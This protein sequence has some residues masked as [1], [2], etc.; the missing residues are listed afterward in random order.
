MKL[1]IIQI[2]GNTTLKMEILYTRQWMN[3]ALK[4]NH[5]MLKIVM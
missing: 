1:Y 4:K 5:W 3:Y 2:T